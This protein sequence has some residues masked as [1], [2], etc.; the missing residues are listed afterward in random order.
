MHLRDG[1][2]V[3]GFWAVVSGV[4]AAIAS[5]I[6]IVEQPTSPVS[7]IGVLCGVAMVFRGIF[8]YRRGRPLVLKSSVSPI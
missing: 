1:D 7:Y 6:R 2:E 5:G 4:G 8:V 3:I